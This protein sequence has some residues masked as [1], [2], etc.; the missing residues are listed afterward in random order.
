MEKAYRRACWFLKEHPCTFPIYIVLNK[1]KWA[2]LCGSLFTNV[3]L[4]V[5]YTITF[6]FWISRGKDPIYWFKKKKLRTKKYSN[7]FKYYLLFSANFTFLVRSF[8]IKT[9]LLPCKYQSNYIAFLVFTLISI[10]IE[11][12][13]KK[14]LGL[15]ILMLLVMGVENEVLW[16]VKVIFAFDLFWNLQF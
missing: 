7:F 15:R 13:Q 12:F 16:W 14:W 10:I 5:G 11:I 8:K 4:H 1:T 6:D 2:G 9:A 3:E